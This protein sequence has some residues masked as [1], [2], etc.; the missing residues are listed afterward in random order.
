MQYAMYQIGSQRCQT[1][2]N[3]H[4]RGVS[5]LLTMLLNVVYQTRSQRY[6]TSAN[7]RNV[8]NWLTTLLRA[9][10]CKYGASYIGTISRSDSDFD[11]TC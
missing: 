6:Q 4:V 3:I 9:I 10:L 7:I 8:S 2:A 11:E 5:N 1:S